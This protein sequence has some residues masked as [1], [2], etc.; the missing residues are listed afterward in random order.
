M[1][2]RRPRGS[3][4]GVLEAARS[5]AEHTTDLGDRFERL[6]AAAL[7]GHPG[8]NGAERFEQVWLWNEWP[9]RDS[10]DIGI[11]LVAKLTPRF[12]GGLVAIQCKFYKGRILTDHVNSF[13]AASGR[14]EF[15]HRILMHTGS[16]IQEVGEQKMRAAYPR[17]EVIDLK[18]M[19]SWKLDWWELARAHHVV[20]EGVMPRRASREQGRLGG[21]WKGYWR[22]WGRRWKKPDTP[23]SVWRW[24]LRL[25]L[26]AEGITM[27]AVFAALAVLTGLMS[28]MHSS[29]DSRAGPSAGGSKTRNHDNHNRRR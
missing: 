17:C 24:L 11:D 14:P 13:L 23:M 28:M 26:L 2:S 22:G 20:A 9:G 1:G 3:L 4:G 27:T 6:A 21:W 25:W 15:T 19:S 5:A 29:N 18:E 12:G 16:G 7:T 8:P 10:H